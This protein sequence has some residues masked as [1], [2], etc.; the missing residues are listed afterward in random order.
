[1]STPIVNDIGDVLN[2]VSV[3]ASGNLDA[4]A[5]VQGQPVTVATPVQVDPKTAAVLNVVKA[6]AP[7]IEGGHASIEGAVLGILAAFGVIKF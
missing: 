4:T 2:A 7:A 5:S 1:M 6:F 3:D